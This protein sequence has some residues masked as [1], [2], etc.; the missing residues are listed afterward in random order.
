MQEW[1]MKNMAIL[2]ILCIG[3]VAAAGE[4]VSEVNGK[5]GYAGGSMEGDWGNNAFASGSVPLTT[6]L[7]FQLDGL[8]TDVSDRDF[9]GSAAH[10]FWRDSDKGLLG[11]VGGGIDEDDIT[12]LRGGVEGEYYVKQFTLSAS[13]GVAS[14][15]YENGPYPFID[16]DVTDFFAGAGVRYYPWEDLMFSVSY[17]HAFDN[18]LV[19]GTAE[20]QTP[21]PGLS[22]FAQV[23]GGDHDYDHALFG[24]QFYLGSRKSLMLRHRADDPP[25]L[26]PDILYGVGLYG[27]EYH[28]QARAFVREHPAAPGSSSY[29]SSGS[30][31]LFMYSYDGPGMTPEEWEEWVSSQ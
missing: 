16:D 20:Y 11:L 8:Y 29:G 25:S 24:V 17:L 22:V 14:L 4:A 9:Y 19:L 28:K 7:G 6:N 15:E 23:A 30:Y 10:L 13:V 21:I 18:G 2:V 3:S 1:S 5:V 27:A 26:V 12:S 31:G